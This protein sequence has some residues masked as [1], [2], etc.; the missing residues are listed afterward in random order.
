MT[1]FNNLN[2]MASAV[3]AFSTNFAS[4]LPTVAQTAFAN[5]ASAISPIIK[6]C[7]VAE[8]L[9]AYQSQITDTPTQIAAQTLCGQC[10]AFGAMNGLNG[11]GVN[12]RGS[13]IMQAMQR[14]LGETPPVGMSWPLVANDPAFDGR[15]VT[16][17]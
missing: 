16:P 9:Y 14:D 4:K 6:V 3:Q 5:A 11:L 15:Y 8:V 13:G 10:A 17:A 2:D 7:D 1:P 12:G